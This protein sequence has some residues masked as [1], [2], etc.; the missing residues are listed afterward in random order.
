VLAWQGVR[1]H[2][3]WVMFL[4]YGDARECEGH[5]LGKNEFVRA[6]VGS[7]PL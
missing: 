7:M 1:E 4:L 6:V 2:K 3:N 5:F